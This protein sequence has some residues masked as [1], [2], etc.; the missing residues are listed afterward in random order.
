MIC[1]CKD[2]EKKGCGEYHDICLNY[3]KWVAW[4]KLANKAERA[5][6]T[7]ATYKSVKK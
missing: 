2:C 1:P 4:K 7:Y 5:D 3:Q 6:K